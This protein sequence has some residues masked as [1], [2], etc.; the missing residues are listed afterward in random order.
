MDVGII[1]T[2][3]RSGLANSVYRGSIGALFL[4]LVLST[5]VSA[6]TCVPYS[7]FQ[8]MSPQTLQTLQAKLTYVGIQDKIVPSVV[9][10]ST[11]QVPDVTLFN[12]VHKPGV[13]YSN[14]TKV[15]TFNATTTELQALISNL[16]KVPA[17]TGGTVDPNPFFSISLVNPAG[18]NVCFESVV[19]A[20]ASA[21]VFTQ[22]R[23][24]LTTNANGLQRVTD[25][26]CPLSVVDPLKPTDVTTQVAVVF[27]GLRL[28]RANGRFVGTVSLKNNG[29]TA[30]TG[31]LSLAVRTPGNVALSNGAGTTC[32]TL[33]AGVPF[34]NV[35]LTGNT[36]AAGATVQANTEFTNPDGGAAATTVTVL[37]G[38]GTR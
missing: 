12:A 37:A 3:R 30:L 16:G 15:N 35:P 21:D 38:P 2:P 9:F 25:L 17:V 22:L 6:Q 34:L 5:Q 10:T 32:G 20:A 33:P 31:P 28:N 14:D 36:L 7:T 29:T 24:S 18:G 27:S 4:S 1:K 19:S 23:A 11:S 26:G 13:D 8:A